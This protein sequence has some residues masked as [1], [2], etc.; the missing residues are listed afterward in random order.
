[1]FMRLFGTVYQRIKLFAG[2]FVNNIDETE[3]NIHF[4]D[5]ASRSRLS[6][7]PEVEN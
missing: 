4:A 7:G 3:N 6:F 1:M 2:F 5:G